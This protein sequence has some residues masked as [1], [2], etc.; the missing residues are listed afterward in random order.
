MR[1][2]LQQ[3][4]LSVKRT[5]IWIANVCV[6]VCVG[7]SCGVV[8][9]G[10]IVWWQCVCV[11]A[12]LLGIVIIFDRWCCSSGKQLHLRAALIFPYKHTHRLC[13]QLSNAFSHVHNGDFK[14]CE[15]F[16]HQHNC[17]RETLMQTCC[18]TG[19]PHAQN[20]SFTK[21]SSQC[22]LFLQKYHSFLS[23]KNL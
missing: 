4:H 1:T 8:I 20:A 21:S 12:A 2:K 17:T 7:C 3:P 23:T 18:Q 15:L 11:F 16:Q 9:G 13:H 6:C 10:V 5:V 14:Q 22:T 19:T